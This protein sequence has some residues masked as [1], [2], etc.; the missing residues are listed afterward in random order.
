MA[1]IAARGGR[2]TTHLDCNYDR[3]AKSYIRE[4]S[5]EYLFGKLV[6]RLK[7][8]EKIKVFV[9]QKTSDEKWNG[10]R[11]EWDDKKSRTEF[12][13]F[14]QSWNSW[15]KTATKSCIAKNTQMIAY[16]Y[17]PYIRRKG[18]KIKKTFRSSARVGLNTHFKAITLSLYQGIQFSIVKIRELWA[19]V[20]EK[21]T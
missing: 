6:Y 4:Y 19:A 21:K 13:F 15:T 20:E 9:Q 17:K 16:W 11:P 2:R 7:K 3:M 12:R 18:K 5:V 10:F 1:D 14:I 8:G